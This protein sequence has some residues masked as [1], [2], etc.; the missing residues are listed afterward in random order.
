M[1]VQPLMPA[2][3]VMGHLLESAATLVAES[4][5]LQ[6][7]AALAEAIRPQLRA[8]NSYYTN[9]I[10]DQH[11]HLRISSMRGLARQHEMYFARLNNADLPQ[12]NDLDGRGAPSQDELAAFASF[13]LEAWLDQVQFMR[14]LMDMGEFW[15]RV[16]GL[17]VHLSH[18]PWQIGSET[19]VIKLEALEPLHYV[20]MTGL[21]ER[22]DRRVLASMLDW[23]LLTATS[24]RSPVRFK[25][26][27]KSLR[28][29]LPRLW[30]EAESDLG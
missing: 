29:L 30:P 12:R 23:G 9:R 10:E 4:H 17:L 7:P 28:W 14:S 26:P 8:M 11:T 25:V 16:Q 27:M 19:S 22:T 24:S 18:R 3:S 1:A 20:A 15:S 2:E 5:Q 21:G 13:F 6:L